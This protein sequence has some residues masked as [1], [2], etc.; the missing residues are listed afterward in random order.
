[1]S[2]NQK[3]VAVPIKSNEMDNHR[4]KLLNKSLKRAETA[5]AA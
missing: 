5:A 4:Q 1:M 2:K 3:T